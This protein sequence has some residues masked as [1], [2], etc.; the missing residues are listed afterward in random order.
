MAYDEALAERIREVLADSA[1]VTEQKMFGG[2]AFLVRG[3]M[4]CGVTHDD[5]ML[6]LGPEGAAAALNRPHV[7]AMDFTGRT[8][9]SMVFVGPQ[10]VRGRAL[11]EWVDTAAAYADR[12]PPKAAKKQRAPAPHP[13]AIQAPGP[14]R[15]P[16][17]TVGHSAADHAGRAAPP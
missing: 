8:M 12:L 6:R 9:T 14:R 16:G 3:H 15:V 13:A 10:G 11:Q 4:V 17:Y 7:R 2:L 5:L 1:D